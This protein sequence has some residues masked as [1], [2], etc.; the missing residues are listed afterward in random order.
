MSGRIGDSDKKDAMRRKVI[1]TVSLLVL[2]AVFVL[3]VARYV[4]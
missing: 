3:F 2:T 1:G 4:G